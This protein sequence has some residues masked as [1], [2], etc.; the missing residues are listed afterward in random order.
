MILLLHISIFIFSVIAYKLKTFEHLLPVD[1]REEQLAPY[2]TKFNC[3]AEFSYFQYC[4]FYGDTI[5]TVVIGD[6]SILAV[7]ESEFH[8]NVLFLGGGSCPVIREMQVSFSTSSCRSIT[9]RFYSNV[10][11][12]EILGKAKRIILLHRSEYLRE[13]APKQY[14][15]YVRDSLAYFRLLGLKKFIIELEVG[16][17][18]TSPATCIRVFYRN[19]EG[20]TPSQVS[21]LKE[22]VRVLLEADFE[23]TVVHNLSF[24]SLTYNDFKDAV[25]LTGSAYRTI[26]LENQL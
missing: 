14:V 20:C 3:P 22:R 8:S 7:A 26:R 4:L 23:N 21:E 9:N 25:H 6:S 16:R 2:H 24:D 11:T 17:I 10:I 15:E 12:A 5:D 1:L 18:D 13:I 19:K